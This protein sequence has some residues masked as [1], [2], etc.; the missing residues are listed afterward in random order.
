MRRC[1]L[2][3]W[4]IDLWLVMAGRGLDEIFFNKPN[5]GFVCP[6]KTALAA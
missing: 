3:F 2:I 1:A 5:R 6:M 4:R